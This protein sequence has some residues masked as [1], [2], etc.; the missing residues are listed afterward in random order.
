MPAGSPFTN[1]STTRFRARGFSRRSQT[2]DRTPAIPAKLPAAMQKRRAAEIVVTFDEGET[3]AA[4][5][6]LPHVD[7]CRRRRWRLRNTSATIV[8]TMRRLSAA[9]IAPSAK[10]APT[11]TDLFDGRVDERRNRGCR[12]RRRSR[13]PPAG[14]GP[15][16]RHGAHKVLPGWISRR[17]AKFPAP[18]SNSL[19]RINSALKFP[20]DCVGNF[21]NKTTQYQRFSHTPFA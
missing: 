18:D 17:S 5:C 9:G 1:R 4:R 7:H 12:V 21:L 20:E 13:R 6:T 15:G 3:P 2:A 19:L 14:A 11:L 16:Q 8:V 10:G